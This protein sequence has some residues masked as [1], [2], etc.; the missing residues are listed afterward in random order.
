MIT[1]REA[2]EMVDM[3]YEFFVSNFDELY[4]EYADRYIVIKNCKVIGDYDTFDNAYK[5]TIKNE[6]IGTF[7]IQ[8]CSK[9]DSN[10]NYFHY[11]NVVFA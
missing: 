1:L 4:K 6:Q 9:S 10:I 11:N 7:I 8:H 3:N 2:K 5:D